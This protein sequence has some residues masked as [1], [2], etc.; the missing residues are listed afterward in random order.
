MKKPPRK[1]GGRSGKPAPSSDRQ[2]RR[3]PSGRQDRREPSPRQEH[4]KPLFSR[5]VAVLYED[6]AVMAVDKP[7]GLPAVPIEGATSPS[8]WSVVSAALRLSRQRAFVVHRIDRFSSGILLFAKTEADRDTLV[9]QFLAH[10][11]VREY[12]AVVRGRLA[13]GE[14]TLVHHFRR[15]GMFQKLRPESDPTAARAEL[16][17]SVERPLLGASLVRLRLVTGLQNQIRAQFSAIGHPV[18][19]DR[20]YHPAE[21]NEGLINRVALHAV[22]LGF[23]HPRSGKSVSIESRLPA[24]FQRLVQK[25]SPPARAR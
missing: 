13:A 1:A 25:L 18:I 19:G 14:G 23:V 12:L 4:R 21:S 7:P 20:K 22:R 17:Y 10:T 3:K 5:E 16:R 15:E 24:D 9:R 8:A 11:P 2:D 6:D